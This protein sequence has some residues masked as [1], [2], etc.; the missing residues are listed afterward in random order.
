[1]KIHLEIFQ[2]LHLN[3]TYIK[4]VRKLN[5]QNQVSFVNYYEPE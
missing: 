1:M 4:E 5:R 3:Y 2:S